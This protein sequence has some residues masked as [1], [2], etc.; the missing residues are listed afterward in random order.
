ML[1]QYLRRHHRAISDCL[2]ELIL[3]RWPL[4]FP[5]PHASPR[6]SIEHAMH[7]CKKQ[8][9]F[10]PVYLASANSRN[11]AAALMRGDALISHHFVIALLHYSIEAQLIAQG[12]G[13]HAFSLSYYI[14]FSTALLPSF[15]T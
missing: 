2:V 1:S 13:M 5:T 14:E 11:F 8:N 9:L 4:L 3:F 15:D 12:R 7:A 6:R 10:S